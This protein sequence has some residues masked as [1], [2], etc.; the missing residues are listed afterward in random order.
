MYYGSFNLCQ[1]ISFVLI[2]INIY[3]SVV[4]NENAGLHVSDFVFREF[5]NVVQ[6]VGLPLLL[7]SYL[8]NNVALTSVVFYITVWFVRGYLDS[9]LKAYSFDSK[10]QKSVEHAVDFVV[11][12]VWL[13][14]GIHVFV[15]YVL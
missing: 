1:V 12:S 3:N 6:I 10:R 5:P 8:F 15:K 7:A 14:F 13:L 2:H 4:V 11:I 9:R